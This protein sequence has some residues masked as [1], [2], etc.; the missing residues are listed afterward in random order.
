MLA[1]CLHH[2]PRCT[3]LLCF[4]HGFPH[5][6][7]AFPNENKVGIPWI[8]LERIRLVCFRLI[9]AYSLS[10]NT[11]ETAEISQNQLAFYQPKSA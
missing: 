6:L 10:Q 7:D 3:A 1:A 11:I 8:C 9:P 2:A 4:H 5:A